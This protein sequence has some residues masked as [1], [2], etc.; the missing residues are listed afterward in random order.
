[1][2]FGSNCQER[3]LHAKAVAILAR[4]TCGDKLVHETEYKRMVGQFFEGSTDG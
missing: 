4:I 1:M 3:A 2:P